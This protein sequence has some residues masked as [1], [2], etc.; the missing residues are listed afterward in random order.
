MIATTPR[1]ASAV[2][3]VMDHGI[4]QAAPS[5]SPTAASGVANGSWVNE[6]C[7]SV[8]PSTTA[9]NAMLAVIVERND[10]ARR[11]SRTITPLVARVIARW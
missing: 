8:A 9:P 1:V 10:V 3:T 7:Q 11:P 2:C 5:D 6:S 4:A